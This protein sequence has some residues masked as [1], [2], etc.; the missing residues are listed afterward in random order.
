VKVTIG[1]LGQKARIKF[2]AT[3]GQ[4]LTLKATEVT[5]ANGWMSVWNPEEKELS[6]SE[7]S[8]S[9]GAKDEFT[10]ASTGTYTIYINPEGSDTGSVTL[11]L[12][13]GS[14]A[15]PVHP[16]GT[17]SPQA[18]PSPTLKAGKT[19]TNSSDVSPLAQLATP[20]TPGSPDGGA[21]RAGA[22]VAPKVVRPSPRRSARGRAWV[23]RRVGAPLRYTRAMLRF[24]A[25]G[26]DGWSPPRSRHAGRGGAWESL[27]PPT[28]WTE[29][30]PLRG[31][32]DATALA[33]QVL[34]LDGLPLA[35]VRLAV[36]DTY[37]ATQS[38]SAGRFL[39]SGLPA[40]HEVLVV[41]GNTVA[42]RERYG[43][44]EVGVDLAAHRTTTLGYTIWLTPLD[45]SGDH[46]VASPTKREV[47]LT[48]PKIPGLEVRLPAGSVITDANG[49][50]VHDLNITAIPTDRPPF[51]LPAFVP[52]P[53]YFT[54]QPG[55]AYINKGAQIVYP[56]W[57]HLPAGQRV[58]FW[59][60]NADGPGWYVYGHGTVTADGKQVMP[61]PG[62][63]VWEFTGAMISGSPT[64]PGSG[65]HGG[66]PSSGDPVD[67]Q[68]GLYVYRKTD[69]A[70]PDTIPILIE[71]TYRQADSNSYSF[72]TATASLYDMRLWSNNNYHEAD[73]VMPSGGRV[74]Y[75]RISPGTGYTE[76]VYESTSVPGPFYAST[77]RWDASVPGWDLTLTDGMIYVFGEFAPLQAIRDRFGNQLT[78]TRE[79]GETG[80]I[81][82]ITSPHG[83]WVTFGYDGSNRVT[84]VTDNGGR[85]L[86]Y[87]Y[88]SGL[89]STVT[90]AAGRTTKLE[91]NGSNQLKSATDPR[92]KKYIETEYDANG[93]VA[94]QT[95]GD[96]GTYSFAYALKG[97]QVEATTV[98]DPRKIESKTTFN[99]EG[100]PISQVRALGTGIQQTTTYEREAGTGQLLSMTDPHGRK[101]GYQQ[102]KY[103]NVTQV[104][105]LAGT[106]SART[107][108]YTYEPG[109]NELATITD[110]L[111]HITKYQYGPK[112]ELLSI[113]DPLGHKTSY[114]YNA[115]GQPIAITNA[116]EK[117][118]KLAYENGALT[119]ITDPLGRRLARFVD[120]LGRVSKVTSP[121]GQANAYEYGADN[122]ITKATD[123][124]GAA[125][126]YE[127]DNDG[128]LT[129]TTD[130]LKHKSTAGYDPMD[131]LESETDALEH[132]TK[133]V[134][135]TDGNLTQVTD[136][137]GKVSKFT[138]DSLN[139]L[140]EARYGVSGETAE[141]T[142]T[143]GYDNANRLTK[144]VDSAT[145]TCTLE[146]DEFDRL[147]SITT[148]TGTVS[149]GYDE[150]EHR[151][152]MTA[153]EQEA[154]KYTYDAAG[155]LTELTRG[156]Q[157]IAFAY[158]AAN[159]HTATKLAD[160]IEE[161][162]GYDEA[163][164]LTSIAYKNGSTT[165]GE[166]DYS[167]DPNGRREAVWGSYARTLLPEAITAATYNADNEQT[168]INGTKLNTTKLSYDLNGNLT[169]T[170]TSQYKWD[171]RNE[172]TAITGAGGATFVYDPF[173]RRITKTLA[174]TT[175]K[176][177]FDGPNV[178]QEIIGS[179]TAD[180]ITGLGPDET[181][182][183][184]VGK[185]SESYLTDAL[186]S[187]IGLANSTATVQT[188]Y[189]YDPFGTTKLTGTASENPYQ[190]AGREYDGN[191]LY[192]DRARYYSPTNT[193]F[194][195]QDPLGQTANG[196]NLY[197]YTEDSPMNATDPYG[198][199]ASLG[200]L[201]GPGT[202]AIP[203]LSGPG[204][205]A[206][207]S[208]SGGPGGPGGGP[209]ANG[210]NFGPG[211]PAPGPGPGGPTAAS[212]KGG[213]PTIGYK[214]QTL[215][216][217]NQ[218][219]KEEEN[220]T[221]GEKIDNQVVLAC[222]L[223]GPTMVI[224][225]RAITN[226][227]KV[228][229]TFCAGFAFGRAIS[230][231]LGL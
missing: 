166:L 126:S 116:L 219:E 27:Q 161:S 50:V 13:K 29:A 188:K 127:Y 150:A 230:E 184:I 83:R 196:P 25:V 53:V 39:L 7:V 54:V 186:G 96:G 48:T 216:E 169:Q 165:L 11:T 231:G 92:G 15:A 140:T 151:T 3:E 141:R 76:A 97:E 2:S 179:T 139:R 142:A 222:A 90:D 102:D 148:P 209:G 228:V 16:P 172:L 195:G 129:A 107:T 78:I 134:Y 144:I 153:P 178:V 94:K 64:P 203:G 135:D 182:A 207:P 57:G 23:A 61:D 181:L 197:L 10:P 8:F 4:L 73:L 71:R 128:G 46:R 114:E 88:A 36:A 89:L 100:F 119:S 225:G 93:R 56:N 168:K 147:K 17:S 155:R 52:V 131:R 163:N 55:R 132:T 5:I 198:T 1:V 70:I 173:G 158:D 189:A 98:T 51:P 33:G 31:E 157:A 174:G 91:Y 177:L 24:H 124:L 120:A 79:S 160:G 85:Q 6:G 143:Y 37:V 145:G 60:Y 81:T 105:R 12:Y 117:T 205:S 22:R 32:E 99:S 227:V 210:G 34:A 146:Y 67:L 20:A 223:G 47:R 115:D 41:E 42:G 62:V 14:H 201:P 199:Q 221:E 18:G 154:L 21:A 84:E 156:S 108:N 38:D 69:L 138:Y 171:A 87:T 113:T 59:D 106:E 40:G 191:G 58:E 215:E 95:T 149:Y 229:G 82:Q 214:R 176:D 104:T 75:V 109:T 80:N 49:R 194:T 66:N 200:N 152:S 35:G 63:R 208:G 183:R 125:T 43:T 9:G 218:Q 74:H 123:P 44:Y 180:L 185:A 118:T 170:S 217:E 224:V 101:T 86:K 26:T 65:P 190:F 204:S 175:T 112:G 226:P 212:Q 136:R 167:Y 68:T 159:R 72:G 206:G 30:P 103:G 19:Y 137:R 133:A 45:R 193:R 187:T 28:P 77:L 211:T 111:K 122:E 110:A 220:E 202:P 192:F 162:Y 130:A 164:Q 213:S 121:G